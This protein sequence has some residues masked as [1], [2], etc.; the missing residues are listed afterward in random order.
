VEIE[1]VLGNIVDQQVDAIVN[2]ANHTLMG[3]GGVDG[4]IHHAAGPRL[5]EACAELGGCDVGDAKATPGFD[6][7]SRWV[8]HA[9]GPVW[10]GGSRGEAGALASAYRRSLEVAD[11]LGAKSVAFPAIST[12]AFGFPEA[13]AARIAVETLRSTR[14]RV[15]LARLVAFDHH[16]LRLLRR[17]VARTAR[18]SSTSAGQAA[19]SSRIREDLVAAVRTV[20]SPKDAEDVLAWLRRLDSDR[21]QVAV[22]IGAMWRG[23]PAVSK[24]RAGV[25]TALTDY[26]DVL[27]NEYDERID[28]KAELKRLGLDRPY[29]VD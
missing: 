14:S 9:V 20:F 11:S 22:V 26:R 28:Y 29:P 8:I 17:E 24:I 2:A 4:A 21:L 10:S 1:V 16:N 15:E 12:G 6:L 23:K 18:L 3:G 7:P 13:E 27:M 25:E 19:S 5:S